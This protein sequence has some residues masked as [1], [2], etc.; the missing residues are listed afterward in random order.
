MSREQRLL[1]ALLRSD[2]RAFIQKVF[3]TLAP[4][5]TYIPTWHIEAIA[6][7]LERVRSGELTRLIINMPPRSLKS[8]AASV[9]FPAFILGLEPYVSDHMHKLFRR[10][11]QK[12]FQRLQGDFGCAL[13]SGGFSFDQ[14]RAIQKHRN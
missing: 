14:D 10:S 6:R 8:I 1:Q 9:A 5:Q 4:G 7:Q 2:F 11:C 3:N 12:A 13:V